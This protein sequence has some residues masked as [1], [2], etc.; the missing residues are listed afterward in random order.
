MMLVHNTLIDF[1]SQQYTNLLNTQGL[2]IPRKNVSEKVNSITIK[3]DSVP[4]QNRKIFHLVEV[5]T[6][7]SFD[8]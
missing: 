8:I 1:A 3:V 5:L 4:Q 2:T 6:Q 7:K